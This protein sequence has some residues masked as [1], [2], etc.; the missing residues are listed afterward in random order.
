MSAGCKE[1]EG[2]S[3]GVATGASLYAGGV[4]EW[5]SGCRVVVK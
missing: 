3:S 4:V 2:E 5:S 1:R